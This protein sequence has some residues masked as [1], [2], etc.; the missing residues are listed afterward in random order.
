MQFGSSP[1]A[2]DERN[3]SICLPDGMQFDSSSL[4]SDGL[5]S[6]RKNSVRFPDQMQFEK[7]AVVS[8]ESGYTSIQIPLPMQFDVSSVEGSDDEREP[9]HVRDETRHGAEDTDRAPDSPR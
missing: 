7:S 1:V 8:E 5:A 3:N 4:V 9:G 2:S 6:D